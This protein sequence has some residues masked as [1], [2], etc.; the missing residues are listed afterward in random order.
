MY[1]LDTNVVSE[2]RKIRMGRADPHVAAWSDSVDVSELYLSAVA[3]EELEIG[4]LGMERRD[5]V[6]GE[7][8]RRW[9]DDQVLPAFEDRILPIDAQV[10]R[11]SAAL[12]VPDRRPIR[13][14]FIAATALVY[15]LVLV[16]RNVADFESM[17]V[18]LLDPWVESR[19][20]PRGSDP[21]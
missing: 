5:R 16:T 12:H 7:T 20:P 3:V 4:V 21:A 13:D 14:G 8:L 18:K 1:L 11:S 17:G 15:G 6:Q 19:T 10:A 2:L 9:M